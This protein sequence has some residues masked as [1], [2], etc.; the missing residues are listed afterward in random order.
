MLARGGRARQL[1]GF[2]GQ[3]RAVRRALVQQCEQPGQGLH[4]S[5][6]PPPV[7]RAPVGV[8]AAAARSHSAGRSAGPAPGGAAADAASSGAAA[9]AAPSGAAADAAADTGGRAATVAAAGAELPGQRRPVLVPR[10]VQAGGAR[11]LGCP[12]GQGVHGPQRHTAGRRDWARVPLLR[13]HHA[14]GPEVVQVELR[15]GEAG[16]R[17]D[18]GAEAA[19]VHRGVLLPLVPVVQKACPDRPRRIG[20]GRPPRTAG[21]RERAPDPDVQPGGPRPALRHAVAPRA[22]RGRGRGAPEAC[23]GLH[24]LRPQEHRQP[25]GGDE[26]VRGEDGVELAGARKLCNG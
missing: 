21:Q 26:G 4:C 16:R 2:G 6:E 1:R 24:R 13:R 14:A 18:S 3:L 20:R 11:L 7:P 8:A 9:D 25:Q 17:R 12:R 19:V 23:P 10:V 22:A 15:R 5:A